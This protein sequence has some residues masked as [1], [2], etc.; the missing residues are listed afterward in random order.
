MGR[1][2]A[3]RTVRD[4]TGGGGSDDDPIAGLLLDGVQLKAV[5]VWK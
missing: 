4:R 2:V 3:C 1:V 5:W